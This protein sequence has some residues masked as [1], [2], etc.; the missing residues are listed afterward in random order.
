MFRSPSLVWVIFRC[1]LPISL[2]LQMR[3]IT[4]RSQENKIHIAMSYNSLEWYKYT[5]YEVIV[6][7]RRFVFWQ[8]K[9]WELCLSERDVRLSDDNAPRIHHLVWLSSPVIL[10]DPSQLV[11]FSSA[12]SV[13][14]LQISF[15]PKA[16]LAFRSCLSSSTEPLE[17]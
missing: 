6:I 4:G 11:Y 7:S 2:R 8:S 10:Y 16:R 3:S 14:S 13:N 1:L 12:K 17:G 9:S 15:I 5:N